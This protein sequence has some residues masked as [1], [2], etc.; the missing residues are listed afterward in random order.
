L[1][2]VAGRFTEFAELRHCGFG[3][4]HVERLRDADSMCQHHE[5]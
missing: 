1:H 3:G 4:S 2:L 5:H